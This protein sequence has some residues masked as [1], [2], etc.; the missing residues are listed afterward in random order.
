M[1][2]SQAT[3]SS[4]RPVFLSPPQHS[5]LVPSQESQATLPELPEL[6]SLVLP[7]LVNQLLCPDKL[8]LMLTPELLLLDTL[9]RLLPLVPPA[10]LALLV[11][12]DTLLLL[13]PLPFLDKLLLLFLVKSQDRLLPL[14]TLELP[15]SD[16]TKPGLPTSRT[17][18]FRSLPIC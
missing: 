11:L 9:D 14:D 10:L 4:T 13:S 6:A 12:L 8:T 7:F 2:S 1:P 18:T 15:P 16:L 17:L 3:L 5:P